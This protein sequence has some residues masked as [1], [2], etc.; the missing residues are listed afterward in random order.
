MT[1]EDFIE[2]TTNIDNVKSYSRKRISKYNYS[3]VSY[4]QKEDYLSEGWE[5]I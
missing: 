5:T 4:S 2:K 1:K 3:S